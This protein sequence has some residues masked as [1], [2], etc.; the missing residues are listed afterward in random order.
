MVVMTLIRRSGLKWYAR[1]SDMDIVERLQNQT[2]YGLDDST[3]LIDAAK[4]IRRLRDLYESSDE[5][6]NMLLSA[7]AGW[8]KVDRLRQ[9]GNA[10]AQAVRTGSGIDDAL[11]DWEVVSGG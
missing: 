6:L 11:E 2:P 5:E 3:V 10:L 4:E 1:G 9:A 7:Q 8:G